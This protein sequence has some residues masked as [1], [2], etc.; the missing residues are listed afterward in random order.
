MALGSGGSG[1]GGVNID[2]MEAKPFEPKWLRIASSMLVS[3]RQTHLSWDT[4]RTKAEGA[5]LTT[6][7]T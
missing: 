4:D 7:P 5:N 3:Q 1:G 2:R 6:E